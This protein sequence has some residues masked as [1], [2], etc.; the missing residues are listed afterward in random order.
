MNAPDF[1]TP[2][3]TDKL[4]SLITP[5]DLV[6]AIPINGVRSFQGTPLQRAQQVLDSLKLW[7]LLDGEAL[8]NLRSEIGLWRGEHKRSDVLWFMVRALKFED[9][10]STNS[11]RAALKELGCL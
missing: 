7:W 5:K 8:E 2:E 3:V 1:L 10:H 9:V 11:L 6:E 4:F